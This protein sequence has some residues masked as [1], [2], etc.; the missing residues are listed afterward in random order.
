[1]VDIMARYRRYSKGAS[2]FARASYSEV[3]DMHTEV[4]KTTLIG[5]H[6]PITGRWQNYLGGFCKQ[7]KKFRYKGA[8]VSFVP[9]NTLPADPLQ[10]SYEAGEPGID[11]RDLT[12]PIIHCG[13]RGQS[14]GN[15]LDE[16]FRFNISETLSALDVVNIEQDTD[17]GVLS[18]QTLENAYYTALSS[19]AFKK[20]GIQTGFIKR[21]L[22]PM[23]Y[24]LSTNKPLN[25][26]SSAGSEGLTEGPI[27][28]M[29]QSYST[30]GYSAPDPSGNTVYSKGNDNDYWTFTV[31]KDFNGEG[32]QID[33]GQFFTSRCHSLGWLDTVQRGVVDY[34]GTKKGLSVLTGLP[35][36]Y[37]YFIMLPPAYK[38]EMYFRVVVRHNFEFQGFRP[39]TGAFSLW[40]TSVL[41]YDGMIQNDP[42]EQ[43]QALSLPES[44]IAT[45]DVYN[46]Q[47]TLV[48]DG[49][50]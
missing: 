21:G 11:P 13:M 48:S 29:A 35:K 15:Y 5:I 1:M 25:Y 41:P 6:T 22:H 2:Q 12:N 34:D 45:M 9:V 49:A 38:T 8:T 20:S 17:A 31:M 18:N 42:I 3:Y 44:K 36:V 27:S 14:M 24:E 26:G 30:I 47:A 43:A 50:M 7:F 39:L 46:G 33:V 40:S 23:V 16:I 19:P 10:V 32:T 4:G 37:M 28:G